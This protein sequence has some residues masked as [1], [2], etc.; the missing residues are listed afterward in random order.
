MCDD[1]MAEVAETQSSQAGTNETG[2][3]P[4]KG[5]HPVQRLRSIFEKIPERYRKTV[6]GGIALVAAGIMACMGT[7]VKNPCVST[8]LTFI[9]LIIVGAG[10]FIL[11]Y[12]PKGKEDTEGKGSIVG[13]RFAWVTLCTILVTA[14]LSLASAW[15][16]NRVP[17]VTVDESV[18]ATETVKDNTATAQPLFIA[19]IALFVLASSLSKC[20]QDYLKAIKK[21]GEVAIEDC[22]KGVFNT[23]IW[24][25]VAM[26]MAA[27]L[28]SGARAGQNPTN[29]VLAL[30]QTFTDILDKIGIN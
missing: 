7:F 13:K 8:A 11:A 28:W 23:A 20:I 12:V 29:L 6:I 16:I 15:L 22:V 14:L 5:L 17:L 10:I 27:I 19:L 3:S 1:E 26:I 25:T 2:E 21:K 30:I 4:K 18:K 9:V 24:L